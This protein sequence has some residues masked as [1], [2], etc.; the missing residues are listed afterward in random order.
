MRLSRLCLIFP[1]LVPGAAA[2]G[3]P[4]EY[5][6]QA[7][8]H[9][10]HAPGLKATEL[11]P[12][13]RRFHLVFAKGDDVRGGLADFARKNHLTDASFTAIGALDHALIGQS[14]HPKH[15][16]RVQRLDEEMEVTA[17]S[18]NI[19]R[20][21]TGA[22]VVHVHCVVALLRDG[23]VYAGHLLDGR[24]SLTLQLY[25]VDSRP[26]LAQAH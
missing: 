26:L 23:K 12:H 18:G 7:A 15:A 20:D 3:T 4:P 16:F 1:L 22:P 19:V 8:I 11:D 2:A 13:V 21:K 25:L 24:V 5:V 17:M 9:E 10:G 6:P 14:D